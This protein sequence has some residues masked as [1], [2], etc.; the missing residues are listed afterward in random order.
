MFFLKI[1][2]FSIKNTNSD[3]LSS[4]QILKEM[5]IDNNIIPTKEINLEYI[6]TNNTILSEDPYENKQENILFFQNT[7]K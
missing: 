5:K 7:K 3:I 4:L 2:S 1:S 6:F